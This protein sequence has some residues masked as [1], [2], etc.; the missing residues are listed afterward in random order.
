MSEEISEDE[1]EFPVHEKLDVLDGK[2][3]YKNDGWW[4]AVVVCDSWDTV[5]ISVYLWQENDDG[6]WGR[7]QKLKIREQEEWNQTRSAVDEFT[8]EYL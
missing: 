2:T 3:I 4:K 6:S 8:E 5:E 7:K 1:S